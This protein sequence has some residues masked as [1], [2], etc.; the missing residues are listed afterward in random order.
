MRDQ[1]LVQGRALVRDQA[2][3][4]DQALV[5]GLV[6][7][8]DLVRLWYRLAAACHH[9]LSP[10]PPTLEYPPLTLPTP[11][12]CSPLVVERRRVSVQGQSSDPLSLAQ[13]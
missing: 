6:L 3:V 13:Q 1:A 9:C 11:Q 5:R 12:M 4:Q 2:L 7:A 10:S 8:R